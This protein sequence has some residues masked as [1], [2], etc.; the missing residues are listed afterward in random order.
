MQK[1]KFRN[2]GTFKILQISDI[3]DS[4][5][6]SKHTIDFIE[7]SLETEKP[8]LVVFT[9]DQIKGYS[10]KLRGKK[11]NEN[12]E[13]TIDQILAPINKYNVPF[14]IAFGNHDLQSPMPLTEQLKIYQKSKNCLAYDT[15]GVSGCANHN[16]PIYS[17]DGKR[18]AFNLY[19][20]DSHGAANLGYQRIEPDQIE[21][22]KNK[23]DELAEQ[24]GG[25]VIP[26]I[27]FQHI[28]VAQILK[29]YKV[30]P[31]RTKGA[32]V[33][34]R[35]NKS[36]YYVLDEKLVDKDAFFGE[37]PAIPD[38]D[39]GLFD[40]AAEK[41]DV[42]GM[43][44]GH[45][46]KN[47]FVGKIDGIELGYTPCCGF[48]V[49]GP[50]HERGGRVFSIN[51]NEPEKYSTKLLSYGDLIGRHAKLSLLARM[52]DKTPTSLDAAIPLFIWGGLILLLFIA[53]IIYLIVR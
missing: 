15:P 44:F 46:H 3:Q 31:K 43:Y 49:Y 40:A 42:K 27:I 37:S 36:N 19:I 4:L 53:F 29:L 47:G 8:D 11:M 12:V 33:G 32:V 7:K 10:G 23:R 50:G 9:G 48:T 35:S 16:L 51:E 14:T 22:Y 26:S 5:D 28:P 6:V 1:L 39:T 41:G 20:I 13:K 34:F 25:K 17:S 52:L 21:W 38:E 18:V 24:N 45:D 2:D 30:V